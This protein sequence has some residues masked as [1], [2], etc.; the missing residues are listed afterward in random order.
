[1]QLSI[2]GLLCL[3]V[4][5]AK[6]PNR[7]YTYLEQERDNIFFT[8]YTPEERVTVAKGLQSMFDVRFLLLISCRYMFTV[9]K[10]L[11]ILVPNT[12]SF[13]VLILTQCQ[14]LLKWFEML[15]T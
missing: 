8:P 11:M 6:T 10:R 9:K 7:T 2:V 3:V 5:G 13:L 1:M 14:E 4:L 12:K 15:P